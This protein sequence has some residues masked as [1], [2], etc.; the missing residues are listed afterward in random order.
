MFEP[1]DTEIC[2]RDPGYDVDLWI[3]AN[4]KTLIEIWLGHKTMKDARKDESLQLEGSKA[5][6]DAF[7]GW[8]ALSHF[9]KVG[10]EKPKQI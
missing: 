5:E 9:A 4:I 6:I 8:F 1:E 2:I 10:G 3:T 7:V